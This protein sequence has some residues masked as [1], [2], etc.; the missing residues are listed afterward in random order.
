MQ[1]VDLKILSVR[2]GQV[3]QKHAVPPGTNLM[4]LTSKDAAHRLRQGLSLLVHHLQDAFHTALPKARSDFIKALASKLVTRIP[5]IADWIEEQGKGKSGVWIF[6]AIGTN[7]AGRA[8]D[9]WTNQIHD[10]PRE[11]EKHSSSTFLTAI[12]IVVL[13][14]LT[15]GTVFVWGFY[16]RVQSKHRHKSGSRIRRRG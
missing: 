6:T 10:L 2:A 11:Y 5:Q 15:A 12:L 16:R 4:T 3:V 7:T 1:I 9:L 14:V 13:F 8:F